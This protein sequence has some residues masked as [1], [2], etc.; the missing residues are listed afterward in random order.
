MSD[1]TIQVLLL[2]EDDDDGEDHTKVHMRIEKIHM[3]MAMMTKEH[4]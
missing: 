2:E 4:E 3:T 1:D